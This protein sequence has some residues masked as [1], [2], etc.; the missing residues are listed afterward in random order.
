MLYKY[1]RGV[2]QCIARLRTRGTVLRITCSFLSTEV[3][4]VP[5]DSLAGHWKIRPRFSC[6]SNVEQRWCVAVAAFARAAYRAV[7]LYANLRSQEAA[8]DKESLKSHGI[9][10]VLTVNGKEPA[11]KD[12]F[13]YR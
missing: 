12:D 10:H 8:K 7:S 4:F 2:Q 3:C 13:E 6:A 1:I 9:T 11:F 5:R